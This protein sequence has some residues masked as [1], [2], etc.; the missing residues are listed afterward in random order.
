MVLWIPTRPSGTNIKKRCPLHH[1][2]LECKSRK[3]RYTWSNRQ[4]WPW[5]TKW[6]RARAKRVLPSTINKYQWTLHLTWRL[7]ALPISHSSASPKSLLSWILFIMSLL[8]KRKKKKKPYGYINKQF[9]QL[10]W[11]MIELYKNGIIL[12]VVFWNLPPH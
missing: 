6:S 10:S 2:G 4:V 5:S 9:I 7:W 3:S 1:K 11:R 8:S 12:Y